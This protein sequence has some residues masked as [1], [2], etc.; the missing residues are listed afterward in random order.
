MCLFRIFTVKYNMVQTDKNPIRCLKCNS[1]NC[2]F[3]DCSE[4]NYFVCMEVLYLIFI[5]KFMTHF[6]LFKINECD[7][8]VQQLYCKSICL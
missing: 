1:N 4:F 8:K 2:I 7:K 5:N 3:A 6:I